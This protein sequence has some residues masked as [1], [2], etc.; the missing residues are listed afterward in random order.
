[1][2][3]CLCQTVFLFVRTQMILGMTSVA[4]KCVRKTQKAITSEILQKLAL[5]QIVLHPRRLETIL[6]PHACEKAPRVYLPWNLQGK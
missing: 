3:V 4:E 1:M 5:A 6:R 2:G